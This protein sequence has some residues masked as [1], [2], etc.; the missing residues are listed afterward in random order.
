MIIR[1]I[2]ILLILFVVIIINFLPACQQTSQAAL[3]DETQTTQNQ[4]LLIG[5]F[6][7]NNPGANMAKTKSFDILSPEAQRELDNIVAKIGA[8]NPTQIFVEWEYDEQSDIDSLYQLYRE[9]TH[10]DNPD[11]SD[12]YRKNEIFQLAFRAAK[13]LT[14][15]QVI[16]IDYTDNDFPF[17]SLMAVVST[18]GQTGIQEEIQKMIQEFTTGSNL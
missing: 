3:I 14:L 5:T 16:G 9:G 10:F 18:S 12:F 17:D 6:H 11:L 1:R 15:G 13:S 7:Y 2:Q 4:V 8:F